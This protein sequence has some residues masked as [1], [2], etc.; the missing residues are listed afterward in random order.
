VI[1]RAFE[2]SLLRGFEEIRKFLFG[3]QS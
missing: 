2:G 1:Q 3:G